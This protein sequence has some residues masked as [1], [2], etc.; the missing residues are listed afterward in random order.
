MKQ[1][2]RQ[3]FRA[4][5]WGYIRYYRDIARTDEDIK[6]V[7]RGGILGRLDYWNQEHKD[8]LGPTATRL[9]KYSCRF[10]E[11]LSDEALRYL[12]GKMLEAEG[13]YHFK[14]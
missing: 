5:Y 12:Y 9:L 11:P 7:M 8:I 2:I 6:K 3:F 14:Q 10:C 1:N 4:L 13:K